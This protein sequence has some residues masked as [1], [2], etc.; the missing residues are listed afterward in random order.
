M[1]TS[2]R[3]HISTTL[4]HANRSLQGVVTAGNAS[5]ISDGAGALILASEEAV[6]EHKLSPLA[7]VVSYCSVGVDPTIMGHG[8]VPAIHKALK[9]AGLQLQ[10]MDL[11]EINEA[12]AAQYLACEKVCLRVPLCRVVCF[13]WV[14]ACTDVCMC[15]WWA[16][17]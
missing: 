16:S 10:D 7:R 4:T 15:F 12:F 14:Y 5:G 9:V 8:P 1:H 11:V 13:S 17:L 6:K 3:T 2:A